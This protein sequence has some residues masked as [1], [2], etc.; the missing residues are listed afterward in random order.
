VLLIDK[1]GKHENINQVGLHMGLSKPETD[2]IFNDALISSREHQLL[3]V[4][5]VY[6]HYIWNLENVSFIIIIIIIVMLK[7]IYIQEGDCNSTIGCHTQK[8]RVWRYQRGYK[9]L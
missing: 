8:R 6:C 3:C 2:K 7:N 5:K 1:F 9:N 4:S